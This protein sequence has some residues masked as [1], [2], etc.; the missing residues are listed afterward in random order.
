MSEEHPVNMVASVSA[1]LKNAAAWFRSAAKSGF[2]P[3]QLQFADCFLKDIG[4]VKNP[5]RAAYWYRKAAE[6]GHKKALQT[7]KNK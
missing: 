7:L 5:T 4:V 3:A 6:Q 2:I 1:K